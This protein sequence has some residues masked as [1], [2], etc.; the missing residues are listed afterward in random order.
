MWVYVDANVLVSTV[1]AFYAVIATLFVVLVSGIPA[2]YK[3]KTSVT[4]ELKH[5]VL[6]HETTRTLLPTKKTFV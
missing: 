6:S 3:H 4:A 5:P 1:P 2:Q